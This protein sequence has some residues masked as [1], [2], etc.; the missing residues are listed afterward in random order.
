MLF[1]EAK[2]IAWLGLIQIV[3]FP[4]SGV[5]QVAVPENSQVFLELL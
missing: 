5:V 1:K 3:L 4:S 2:R